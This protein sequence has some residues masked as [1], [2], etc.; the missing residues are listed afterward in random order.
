[1]KALTVFAHAVVGWALCAATMGIGLATL[2]LQSALIIH[3]V[4]APIFF[5]G[6]SLFYFRRFNYTS[7]L[8]TA[9]C[10]V[11]FVIA[12]DFFIVALLINKS[13]AMF[14]S[15][16][17]TW[18]PFALIFTSTYL[19]GFYAERRPAPQGSSS[20]ANATQGQHAR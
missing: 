3:A 15:P 7:P 12:A 1:M 6:V 11:A 10:F 18:I 5:T 20:V 17:G 16:L 8:Q 19:A 14:A 9:I 13:L 4:A 2:P